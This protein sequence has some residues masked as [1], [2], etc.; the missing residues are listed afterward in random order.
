LGVTCQAV[1]KWETSANS[2]DITLIPKLAELFG[3]SISE[4][5]AEN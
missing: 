2:P 3:V 4:L 5:F 1:S